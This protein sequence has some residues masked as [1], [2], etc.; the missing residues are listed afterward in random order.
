MPLCVAAAK[1]DVIE[2]QVSS[3]AWDVGI[4]HFPWTNAPESTANYRGFPGFLRHLR[5][6]AT[7]GRGLQLT[8]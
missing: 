3:H 1:R 6:D 5:G 7:W 2:E 4:R 8:L